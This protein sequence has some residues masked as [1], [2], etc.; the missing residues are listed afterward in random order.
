LLEL[1]ERLARDV[2]ASLFLLAT[3]R[4]DFAYRWDAHIDAETI[5]LE[6]L[7]ADMTSSLVAAL[8]DQLPPEARDRIVQ[9]A[10]GNPFFAEELIQ[11]T[12]DRQASD[13]PDSVQAVLA[14][15]IDLLGEAEKAALQAAA[16]IG[17]AFWTGPMYELVGEHTP[18][19]ATL[20]SR[21]FVRRR[22]ASSLEGEVEYV[23]KHALTRE[24][25]YNGLTKARRARL[26]AAFAAWL[27]RLGGEHAP[28]LAHHYAEAVRPEDVDVAWP[29]GGN[30]LETLRAKA[31]TWLTRAAESAMSRYE[32]ADAVALFGRAIPLSREQGQLWRRIA[33][34]HALAYDGYSLMDAFEHALELTDDEHERAETYAE[35]AF[36]STLRSGMWPRRPTPEVMDEWTSRALAGVKPRSH[37]HVKALIARG[38]DV[39]PN[40]EESAARAF[41][42]AEELGDAALKSSARDAAGV[43]AFRAGRFEEAYELE[44]SRFDLRGKL[45]DPDLVHDLYLSTIPTAAATGRLEESRRLARELVDIVAELTPHHRLHGA[46]ILIEGDE[47]EGTWD[48]VIAREGAT[49][50]AVEQNRDTPCVRNARSL[51]VCALA[52][53]LRGDRER[54]AELEALA[55][56]LQLEGHG[57]ATTTPRARLA[58]ARGQLDLLEALFVDDAWRSRQS[59]FILPAAAARLDVLAVLGTAADVETAF[60]PPN[61]YVEPFALRALG[62]AKSDDNL[63]QRA[64]ERFRA[65]SLDWHAEQT[66]HLA[67]L[68]KQAHG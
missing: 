60:A 50:D 35:L 59:W 11:L 47:L 43:T 57:V 22:T 23:F 14:A 53:E 66:A 25:A 27:E 45:E 12:L 54:S 15:R 19:L 10:E 51:L 55:D 65:L 37:E 44:S 17:R 63:L 4:P 61:S 1:L 34:A 26:H 32:L 48:A 36:E 16:V 31:V 30:E 58:I 5:L 9:R 67:A 64:D 38:F 62:V 2:P 24:V 33:R 46:A 40:S 41:E 42:I 18:D 13:I 21:D 8:A 52:R 56:D 20:E 3:A 68:R 28:L 7:S 49:I 29:N 39:F 6:P